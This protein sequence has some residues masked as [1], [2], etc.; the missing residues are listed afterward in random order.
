MEKHMQRAILQ[1]TSILTIIIVGYNLP[2]TLLS[3]LQWADG[4][5]DGLS[6]NLHG[7]G[8]LLW[9]FAEVGSLFLLSMTVAV[10]AVSVALLSRTTTKI[11]GRR[12]FGTFRA[13]T[14]IAAGLLPI[15][16]GVLKAVLG[17]WVPI[18]L[19]PITWTGREVLSQLPWEQQVQGSLIGLEQ[20]IQTI[21][22]LT[23]LSAIGLAFTTTTF[24]WRRFCRRKQ[25][26]TEGVA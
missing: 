4:V 23:V 8:A 17:Y 3:A 11:T 9:H 6:Q 15:V 24:L 19:W 13:K 1:I 26:T 12:R 21:L 10:V 20:L 18:V 22:I 16:V 25:T 14:I 2:D 7:H 5:A